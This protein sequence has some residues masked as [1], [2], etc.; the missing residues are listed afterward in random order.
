MS[1]YDYEIARARQQEIVK[2]ALNSHR[3]DASRAPVGRHRSVKHRL[4]PLVVALGACAAA[5]TA[6]TVSDA[7]S[8][9]PPVQ[10]HVAHISARQLAREIRTLEAKGYV[11]TACTVRG[12]LMRNYSTG[13]SV[14]VKL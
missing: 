7:Q 11:P 9:Q 5:G 1:P 13:R 10:Q 4:V 14:T 12:T 8:N 2:R 6:A 3:S